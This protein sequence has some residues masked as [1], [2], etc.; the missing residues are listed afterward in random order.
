[1]ADVVDEAIPHEEQK[2]T[3]ELSLKSR[4]E[5]LESE[6]AHMRDYLMNLAHLGHR[7]EELV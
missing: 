3:P 5:V 1:M 6:F 4:I 2:V 7:P